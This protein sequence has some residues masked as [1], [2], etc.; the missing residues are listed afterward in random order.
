MQEAP[1]VSLQKEA[2]PAAAFAA[3]KR[4]LLSLRGVPSL[5]DRLGIDPAPL[6]TNILVQIMQEGLKNLLLLRCLC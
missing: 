3:E 4:L 5:G 6:Y 2:A 1:R